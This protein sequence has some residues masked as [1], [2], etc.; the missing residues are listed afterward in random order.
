MCVLGIIIISLPTREGG[1]GKKKKNMVGLWACCWVT[2]PN[3]WYRKPA[4]R[5]DV[6]LP[7]AK[8]GKLP[9]CSDIQSISLLWLSAS[10]SLIHQPSWDQPSF[11]ISF[12]ISLFGNKKEREDSWAYFSLYP[13]PYLCQRR[14]AR[15]RSLACGRFSES[16]VLVC[17]GQ[18][19]EL[20]YRLRHNTPCHQL[21]GAIFITFNI[22]T[23]LTPH[24]S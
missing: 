14:G 15:D 12:F 3:S 9:D 20:S 10:L 21:C 22:R 17:V 1:G 16:G 5:R 23:S 6:R 11:K 18:G 19:N 8:G 4:N 13:P 24:S 7:S 2:M